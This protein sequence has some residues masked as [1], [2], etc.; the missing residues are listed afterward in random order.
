METFQTSVL[1]HFPQVEHKA[2]GSSAEHAG[3]SPASTPPL[4]FI[5][6]HFHGNHKIVFVFQIKHVFEQSTLPSCP[7]SH[8]LPPFKFNPSHLLHFFLSIYF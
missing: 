6:L 4:G 8:Y 7:K 2:L 5:S 1:S 3:R